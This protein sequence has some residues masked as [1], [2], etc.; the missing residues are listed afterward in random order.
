MRRHSHKV[1]N[2]K[3]ISLC[4][5]LDKGRN[6]NKRDMTRPNVSKYDRLNQENTYVKIA[7]F[8]RR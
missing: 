3:R 6:L 1:T 5:M 7:E 4:P 2:A 8:K